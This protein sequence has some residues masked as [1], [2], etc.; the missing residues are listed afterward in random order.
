MVVLGD[1]ARFALSGFG[2]G[3]F[4]TEAQRH[5]GTEEGAQRVL[6]QRGRGELSGW[7]VGD[8]LAV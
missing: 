2:D 1:F 6:T 8:F 7:R 3:D 4:N 5:R